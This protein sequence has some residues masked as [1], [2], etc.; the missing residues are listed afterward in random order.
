MNSSWPD[1]KKV[2]N[3]LSIIDGATVPSDEILLEFIDSAINT[4]ETDTGWEPFLSLSTATERTVSAPDYLDGT[5]NL[6]LDNGVQSGSIIVYSGYDINNPLSA[7][8]LV[9]NTDYKIVE[10]NVIQF[11]TGVSDNI[12]ITARWGYDITVPSRAYNCVLN[13]IVYDFLLYSGSAS[14]RAIKVEQDT[15]KFTFNDKPFLDDLNEK[16]IEDVTYYMRKT[17]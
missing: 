16:Y 12:K 13:K 1:A 14:A 10:R 7:K 11:L 2:Q 5:S 9:E 6:Y 17:P 3:R 8:L 15:V 4:F